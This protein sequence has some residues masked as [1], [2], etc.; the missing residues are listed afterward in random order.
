MVPVHC[1]G[2]YSVFSTGTTFLKSFE[3][4]LDFAPFLAAGGSSPEPAG[5]EARRP[6]ARP[7]VKM[8]I[9]KMSCQRRLIVSRDA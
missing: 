1:V 7:L 2:F 5:A 8:E 6:R 9:K 3:I 4:S